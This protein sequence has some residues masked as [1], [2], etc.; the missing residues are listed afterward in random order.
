MFT[1]LKGFV[2]G[3]IAGCLALTGFAWT[4]HVVRATDGFKV[5]SKETYSLEK[6]YVDMRAWGAV[7]YIQN[8]DVVQALARAGYQQSRESAEQTLKNGRESLEKSLQDAKR[9]LSE[10][11]KPR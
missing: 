5:V 11:I 8:R 4:H 9:E 6:I 7:D 3:F 10:A 2:L 1:W